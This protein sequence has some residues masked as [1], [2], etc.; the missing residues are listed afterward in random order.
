MTTVDVGDAFELTFVTTTGATVRRSWYDPDDVPVVELEPIV[1]DPAG[2]GRFPHTF[3]CDYAGLWTVRAT[4]TGTATA[5][6]EH[7]VFARQVPATKPLAVIGHVTEQFGALTAAQEGLVNALLRA[8]S[9]LVRARIPALD[10][11]LADGRLDA[12]LVALA[13]TNMVLRV[14][15]NPGGLRA[16]TVGPFSRTYDTTHAAGLLVLSSDETAILTPTV[17]AATAVNPIGTARI[18][19]GMAP[20]WRRYGEFDGWRW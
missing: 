4:V 20:T 2:S 14:L 9:K 15:R 13:V 6:E 11:M 5:V 8:A 18:T 16:E 10:A 7:Y 3:Q 19:P 12:D 17:T 1:E